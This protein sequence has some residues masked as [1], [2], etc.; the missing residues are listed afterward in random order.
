M[1]AMRRPLLALAAAVLVGTGSISRAQ[2][3]FAPYERPPTRYSVT[4]PHDAITRLEGRLNA[5]EV[6][7]Q[8]KGE[9]VVL[10]VLQALHVPVETQMLVF[11]KTSFQKDLINP[12]HPRALYYSDDCYVGWVPGGRIEIAAVDPKLGPVFYF[13]DPTNPND[14]KAGR[15]PRESS[16][17]E[18]HGGIFV[19]GIPGLFSRSVAATAAGDPLFKEGDVVFDYRTPFGD[20]WGGWYVTG[21]PAGLSQRG[22][23]F[24]RDDGSHVVLEPAPEA[25]S[26]TEIA[27]LD[28]TDYPTNT[29][30]IVALLVFDYQTALQNMLTRAGIDC[31]RVLADQVS[32]EKQLNETFADP[33][34]ANYD[35]VKSVC[36]ASA[37]DVVDALLDKDEAKLPAGLKAPAAFVQA[38]S[39]NAYRAPDGSSLKDLDLSDHLFKNRCGYLIYTAAFA[40]LP[41]PLK[42]RIYARLAKAVAGTQPDPRYAY[43]GSAERKRIEAILD[44]TCPEYAQARAG[45]E[46]AGPN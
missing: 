9:A 36:D 22:N 29:S 18:C 11:S 14:V 31:R 19:P 45:G 42:R 10:Q 38:F 35:D 21:L 26:G 13:F 30:G 1:R 46:K 32:L 6:T 28:T 44:A 16:C 24:A 12:I 17:L 4:R 34:D 23:A 25:R 39:A 7:L 27:G 33:E 43:L 41:P 3:S 8:G 15:F 5:G 2:D 20:R 37:Q 40:E